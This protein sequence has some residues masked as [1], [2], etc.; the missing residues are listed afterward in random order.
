MK[1]WKRKSLSHVQLFA[2]PWTVACQAPLSMEFFRP[3]YWS[4]LPF[5]SSGDLPNPGIEPRSPTLQADSLPSELPG[6]PKNA[7]VGSLS[8][9]RWIFLTQE[10]KWEL[11]HCRR[12]L[13][14]LS[15]EGDNTAKDKESRTDTALW[16]QICFHRW[17]SISG[18][19]WSVY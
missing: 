16:L 12:I 18:T 13:I 4:G 8:L 5:S 2:T 17:V 9:L 15:Y 14:Q 11:L 3:E 7:G 19:G 6:K 1:K 10:S